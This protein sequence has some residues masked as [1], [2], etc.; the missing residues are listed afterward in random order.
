MRGEAGRFAAMM[1]AGAE[2]RRRL[3]Q[4]AAGA[5]LAGLVKKIEPSLRVLPCGTAAQVEAARA[6]LAA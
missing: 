3:A 1:E 5:V 4:D 6:E 2:L